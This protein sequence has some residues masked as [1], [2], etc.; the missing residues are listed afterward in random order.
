MQRTHQRRSPSDPEKQLAAFIAKFEPETAELIRNCRVALRKLL[1]TALELV[2]DNYNF[3]VIGYC[4]TAKPSTCI[5]SLAA[6]AAIAQ[7]KV[8]LVETGAGVTV[9]QSV[10]AKQRPRRKARAGTQPPP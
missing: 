9:I 5:V 6:A 10:S 7:A 3:I 4:S 1:P 2:Y 8:P